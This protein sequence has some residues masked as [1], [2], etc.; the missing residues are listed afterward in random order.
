MPYPAPYFWIP[1]LGFE[2]FKF[3]TKSTSILNFWLW[4]LASFLISYSSSSKFSFTIQSSYF[5]STVLNGKKMGLLPPNT[6]VWYLLFFLRNSSQN[7]S[8]VWCTGTWFSYAWRSYGCSL[9]SRSAWVLFIDT[10]T[11]VCLFC[12]GMK[13]SGWFWRPWTWLVRSFWLRRNEKAL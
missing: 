12:S 8:S 5:D 7:S 9:M 6:M 13:I 2:S 10:P 4:Y 3:Y 11:W 1:D